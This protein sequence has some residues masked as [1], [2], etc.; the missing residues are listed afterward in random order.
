M[1]AS[2][3]EITARRVGKELSFRCGLVCT[4]NQARYLRVDPE[5][6]WL[7]SD[8]SDEATLVVYSNVDWTIE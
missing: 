4:L 7:L 1:N 6:V 8:D 5:S 3:L 2:C